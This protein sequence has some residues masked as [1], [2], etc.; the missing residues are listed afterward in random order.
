[1]QNLKVHNRVV[2]GRN[3]TLTAAAT[4]S[5]AQS[6]YYAT[7]GT[8]TGTRAQDLLTAGGNLLGLWAALWAFAAVLC[9]VDMVNRHTRHGLSLV[10]GLAFAWGAGYALVWILEG[11]DDHL[12]IFAA[13]RWIALATVI[14]GFVVKVAALQAML[15]MSAAPP[16]DAD[17]D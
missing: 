11:L 12:V 16:G 6:V 4:Y 10:V 1:M 15:R 7:L 9:I 17:D 14:L 2:I 3:I 8:Q 5:L 13:L